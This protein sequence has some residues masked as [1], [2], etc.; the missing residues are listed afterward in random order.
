ML[1]DK[2]NCNIFVL[3]IVSQWDYEELHFVWD[4]ALSH[5]VLHVHVWLENHYIGL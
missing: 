3:P 1:Q 2:M 4:E 5:F